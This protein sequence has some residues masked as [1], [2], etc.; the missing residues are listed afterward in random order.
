MAR[1]NS[2]KKALKDGF[3]IEVRNQ[4]QKNGIK[5]RRDTLNQLQVAIKK[6]KINKDVEVIGRILE[7]QM[8]EIKI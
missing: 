6:Y 3:Y 1:N 4:N 5:I 2:K 8:V 7:G